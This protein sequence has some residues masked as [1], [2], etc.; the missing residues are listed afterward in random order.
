MLMPFNKPDI[1]QQ[2]KFIE[3]FR[4]VIDTGSATVIFKSKPELSVMLREIHENLI[5]V[6]LW[7]RLREIDVAAIEAE[8]HLQEQDRE[9]DYNGYNKHEEAERQHRIQRDLK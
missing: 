3:G 8:E 4:D 2:I 1:N 5:A 9:P 7:K 6:R